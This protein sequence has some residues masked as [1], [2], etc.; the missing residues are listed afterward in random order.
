MTLFRETPDEFGDVSHWKV[1][2]RYRFLLFILSL[3]HLM[4]PPPHFMYNINNRNYEYG[5]FIIIIIIQPLH[6]LIRQDTAS[7]RFC[8]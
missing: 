2:G 4:T 6:A 8:G 7:Y 1:I 3:I 5:E